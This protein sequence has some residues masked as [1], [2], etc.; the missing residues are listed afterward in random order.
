MN[1]LTSN[2]LVDFRRALRGKKISLTGLA[3]VAGVGR[4]HLSQA[5]RGGRPGGRTWP[6]VREAVEAIA[7][8]TLPLFD[9]LEQ[10]ATWNKDVGSEQFAP[11]TVSFTCRAGVGASSER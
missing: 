5:L 4:S 11:S 1:G 6:D 8:D 3:N 7:P 9:Q 2:A 10:S